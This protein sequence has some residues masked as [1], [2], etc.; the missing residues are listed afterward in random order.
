MASSTATALLCVPT[1][2]STTAT[3]TVPGRKIGISRHEAEIGGIEV[4]GW[5]I[6]SD[7]DDVQIGVDAGN[8]TLHHPHVIVLQAEIS[9]EC[10]ESITGHDLSFLPFR[11]AVYQYF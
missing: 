11:K 3:W 7:V 9:Q 5:D 1:P 10:K 4:L 8:Y 2:G 6:M